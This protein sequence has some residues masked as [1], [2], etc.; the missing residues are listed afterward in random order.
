MVTTRLGCRGG[1]LRGALVAAALVAASIGAAAAPAAA[2]RSKDKDS[3]RTTAQR[4]DKALDGGQVGDMVSAIEGLARFDEPASVEALL[5]VFER[6]SPALFANARAVLG[7]FSQPASLER[8]VAKGLKHRA[9]AVRAQVTLAL[10]E[11]RPTGLDWAGLLGAALDDESPAVRAAAVRELSRARVDSRLD[12]I[13]ELATDPA[14]EVRAEVPGALARLGGTRA[15]PQLEILLKDPR[16]R[17]RLETIH[18]LGDLRMPEVVELLIQTM[19]TERGRLQEDVVAQL[20][21]LTGQSFGFDVASWK[22]FVARAPADF[23]STPGA[24]QATRLG[25]PRFGVGGVRYHTIGTASQRFILVTDLSGSMETPIRLPGFGEPEP[26]IQLVR[27]ELTRL[28]NGLDPTI[29]FDLITFRDT[30]E[31][32]KSQMTLAN[33]AQK[34]A[35]LAQVASYRA[36]GGTNIYGALQAVF[37][38]AQAAMEDTTHSLQDVDTIFL[39]SDGAPSDGLIRDTDLL[40]QYVAERNRTLRL[41][42]HCISLVAL[43]ETEAETFLKKLA[44]LGGGGYTSPATPDK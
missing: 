35:A 34:R 8:L 13:I 39:L 9:P 4:L 14:E 5:T 17:V 18:A 36:S 1:P 30:V 37:D 3:A 44:A 33:D 27:D 11:A 24:H 29:G 7:G 32:W 20:E 25:T 6:G 16:W 31:V 42:I 28:I 26:R 12:R 21:Q 15:L 10:G 23:L 43:G 2:Q 38:I 40:L 41:R 22:D 19:E